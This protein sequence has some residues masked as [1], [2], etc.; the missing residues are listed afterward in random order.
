MNDKSLENEIQVNGR[1]YLVENTK[2]EI[3]D[4][5]VDNH[6]MYSI[7]NMQEALQ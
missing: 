2:I 7:Q 6:L 1:N 4:I 3:P 5:M